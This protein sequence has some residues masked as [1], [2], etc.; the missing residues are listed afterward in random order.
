MHQLELDCRFGRNHALEFECVDGA[1]DRR[2]IKTLPPIGDNPIDLR[3]AGKNRLAG[4]MAV[5]I[6]Q[7]PRRDEFKD[8]AVAVFFEQPLLRFCRSRSL[9]FEQC[10]QFGKGGF[11]L[12]V[13]RQRIEII[14]DARQADRL[15]RLAQ[16]IP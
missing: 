1:K 12:R 10:D 3:H 6:K 9:V 4:K 7:V 16:A 5:K 13:N 15:D 2:Q 11:A 8:C 14:P